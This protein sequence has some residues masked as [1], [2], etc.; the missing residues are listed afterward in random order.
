MN[1]AVDI[2]KLVLGALAVTSLF[3][4]GN[5][6]AA[7]Q[8]TIGTPGSPDATTTVDSRYLPAPPH[9]REV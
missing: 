6:A 9:H 8:Q 2:R 7:E 4:G 3:A 5:A 1:S